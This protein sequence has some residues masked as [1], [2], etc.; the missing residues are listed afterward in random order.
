MKAARSKI[1][2]LLVVSLSVVAGCTAVD[3]PKEGETVTLEP[4]AHE[5]IWV[6]F[7]VSV[8]SPMSPD[9]RYRLRKVAKDGSVELVFS[10]TPTES[11]VIVA[12]PPP[13]KFE[14]G[15]SLPTVVVVESNYEKQTAQ[16]K[17]LRTK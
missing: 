12:K 5:Y 8:G 10:V 17:E 2:L 6:P 1:P 11:Q 14:K 3:Q 4:F 7:T 13:K 15:K 16:L 9:G